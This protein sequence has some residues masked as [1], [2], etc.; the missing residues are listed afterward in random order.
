MGVYKYIINQ[1]N[2]IMNTEAIAP[3]SPNTVYGQLTSPFTPKQ[4]KINAHTPYDKVDENESK[5]FSRESFKAKPQA[6][7]IYELPENDDK[8]DSDYPPKFSNS[9]E[10]D[11]KDKTVDVSTFQASTISSKDI[12]SN[13]L[14]HGYTTDQ[15]IAVTKAQKAYKNSAIMT[16]NPTEVLSKHSYKVA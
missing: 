13:S 9:E 3:Y 2:K 4:V 6:K 5:A 12:V 11:T 14:K 7:M 1:K 15:A 16:K 10:K 8:K